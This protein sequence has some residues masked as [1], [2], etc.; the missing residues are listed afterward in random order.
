MSYYT[1]AKNNSKG[2]LNLRIIFENTNIDWNKKGHYIEYIYNFVT[3][4]LTIEEK[5]NIN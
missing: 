3:K 4:E 2:E 5:A 1:Q